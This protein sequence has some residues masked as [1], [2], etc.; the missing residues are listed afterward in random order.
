[1]ETAEW[2]RTLSPFSR[3]WIN[4]WMLQAHLYAS[5]STCLRKQVG[6]VFVRDQRS[7]S[8]GYNGSLPGMDH[9]TDE[10]CL[11]LEGRSGCQRTTHAEMNAIAHA[12]KNGLSLDGCTLYVTVC[13]CLT[14]FHSVLQAGVRA[15]YY[16]EEYR[17]SYAIELANQMDHV[18]LVHWPFS[19]SALPLAAEKTV[20][21]SA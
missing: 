4:F 15:I 17:Q 16:A 3:N 10:G 19:P 14:C 1:M 21:F 18:H 2:M 13:P 8:A 6:A 7:I 20:G 11:E 5:R 9:C 12:A